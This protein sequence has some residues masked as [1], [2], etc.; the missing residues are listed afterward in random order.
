[1]TFAHICVTRQP[2]LRLHVQHKNP[3]LSK[4]FVFITNDKPEEVEGF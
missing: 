1:M 2:T 3:I 4:F